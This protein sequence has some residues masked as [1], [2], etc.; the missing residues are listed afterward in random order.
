M[1]AIEH[2]R[3]GAAARFP[4]RPLLASLLRG[5]DRAAF[6]L[7]ERVLGET[8]SRTATF[9]DLLHPAQVE[10][11]NLWYAGRVTYADEVRVAAAVRRIVGRLSP[12]PH[13]RP[14]SRA[15]LCIL[16]VPYGDP[17]DLGLQMFMLAMQDHGW[18]AE[19]VCPVHHL[20]EMADL[21]ESRRPQLFGLSAG[22]MPPLG[23]VERLISAV[24]RLR[25]PALVGGVAFNR[26]PHLWR[27]L[28]AQGLGTDARVGVVLAERLGLR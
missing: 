25:V 12:T 9:A 20:G 22:V 2:H 19:V 3:L 8:R 17:H 16:A 14:V 15:P 28:G 11:S 6:E 13:D 26:R 4:V 23:E 24:R 5:D 7:A 21:V 27:R 1:L 10:M 18:T